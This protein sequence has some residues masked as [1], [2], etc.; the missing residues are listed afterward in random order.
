MSGVSAIMGIGA[1]GGGGS[2]TSS[3]GW[4]GG[5]GAPGYCVVIWNE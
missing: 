1:G 3:G 2:S 5:N 4:A